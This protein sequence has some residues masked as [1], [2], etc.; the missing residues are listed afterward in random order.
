VAAEVREL[1][2]P[3]FLLGDQ[4]QRATHRLAN[5]SSNNLL[6]GVVRRTFRPRRL[7]FL[8]SAT[9]NIGSHDVQRA[10]VGQREKKRAQ[11]SALRVE[12]IATTGS[13]CRLTISAIASSSRSRIA[14]TSSRSS[15]PSKRAPGTHSR[16]YSGSPRSCSPA[17]CHLDRLDR[18]PR[19]R[20]TYDPEMAR[21]VDTV[22]SPWS[23]EQAFAYMADA[24]N[25]AEWDPGVRTSVL[26]RGVAPGPD[27]A[28]DVVVDAGRRAM[29][30]TY[31]ITSWEP[32]RRLV[33]RA[34]TRWLRS[35][36]EVTIEPTAGG[37]A[38]TYDAQLS[39]KSGLG[40]FDPLLRRS[41][42]TIGDRAAAGLRRVLET[43]SPPA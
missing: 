10:P 28:F 20:L 43:A 23:P 21:Y 13:R 8:A 2:G 25:F 42:R 4:R 40:I 18:L 16:C 11:R 19:V 36:D 29:T 34:E 27:A 22:S 38:V 30:L 5:R 41:F 14:A 9:R 31:E 26:V 15:T 33:L 32:P 35:V 24:R 12:A 3:A 37:T 6:V 7:A 17:P 1:D 39:L